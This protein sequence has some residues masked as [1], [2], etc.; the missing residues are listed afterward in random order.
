MLQ[1]AT[2]SALNINRNTSLY[3]DVD[4]W[5]TAPSCASFTH[6]K[7]NMPRLVRQAPLSV[8]LK[9]YLDPWDWLLWIA[10][11]LNDDVYDDWITAWGA[12]LGVGLNIVFIL[13]R[14]VSGRASTGSDDGFSEM[15]VQESGWFAWLV[16]APSRSD[17]LSLCPY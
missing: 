4:G 16:C 5:F 2:C 8:R 1:L 9:A 17:V 14:G 13:A 10:E 3:T 11:E 6:N 12:P 7:H 15:G